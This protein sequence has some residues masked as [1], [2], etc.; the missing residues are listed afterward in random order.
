LRIFV[1]AGCL[2]VAPDRARIEAQ[3]ERIAKEKRHVAF[4]CVEFRDQPFLH[5][6]IV[7]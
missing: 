4:A 2:A 6:P 5:R 7:I 1:A 3:S